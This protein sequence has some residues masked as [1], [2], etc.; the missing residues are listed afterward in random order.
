MTYAKGR[1]STQSFGVDEFKVARLRSSD[2]KASLYLV[3]SV[4]RNLA[5][6]QPLPNGVSKRNEIS[7]K[8]QL[9]ERPSFIVEGLPVGSD[10]NCSL[11]D[12]PQL[13]PDRCQG[14]IQLKKVH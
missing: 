10:V 1:L 12:H 13:R 14:A 6:S 7:V 2:G 11:T 5:T 8:S 3:A 4:D 9:T